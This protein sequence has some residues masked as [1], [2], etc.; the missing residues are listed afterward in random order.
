MQPQ[1]ARLARGPLPSLPSLLSLLDAAAARSPP[2]LASRA[3]AAIADALSLRAGDAG[4]LRSGPAGNKKWAP[5]LALLRDEI[6][7]Q[8]VA[9]HESGEPLVCD[10]LGGV[11]PERVQE[12][13]QSLEE[14]MLRFQREAD[15]R[16]AT[17]LQAAIA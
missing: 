12:A 1:L 9:V 5:A 7:N 4:G 2:Q 14:H 11:G 8:R 17:Q 13:L 16:A 3:F 6:A 10:I 15:E